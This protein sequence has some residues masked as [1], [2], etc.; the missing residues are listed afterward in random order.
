MMR[1]SEYALWA[2]LV[3]AVL[4]AG[5]TMVSLARSQSASAAN[6]EIYRQLDLFGEVLERVAL[7][8]CREARRSQADRSR[9]STAC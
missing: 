1:K 9:P 5:S 7:G 2:L 8:L 6:S 4:A 3:L